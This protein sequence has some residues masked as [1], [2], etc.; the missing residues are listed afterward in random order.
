MRA[1]VL[2]APG[3]PVTV[4]EV[5]LAAPRAGEV[6]VRL[7][8]AGVCHSDLHVRDGD[9]ALPLPLVLGHEGSGTVVETGPGVDALSV[10]DHVVLSWV[11]PCRRCVPCR[12]GHP[13]QCLVASGVVSRGGVLEDGTSRLSA[14][15]R[16]VHH[17]MGVSAFAEE[18]VV[19]AS[20]AIRIDPAAPLEVV[21]LV[22]C[23][24]ATGVGAVR[25]TAKVEAGSTVVVLGCGGVGLSVVQGARLAGAERI[26][27]V[28]LRAEKTALART[29]GATD[30]VDAS[31]SD[32]VEVVRELFPDGVDYAFDAIGGRVLTEQC[33][34]VLGMGGTAVV[35]GIP[36]AGVR[37]SFDAGTLV[38]KEQRILGSNYGGIDP[39]RDI[40]QL[41]DAYLAG[42]LLLD[43]LVSRRRPLEE[44]A[45]S[46]DEL[47]AGTALRQLLIP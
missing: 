9:W 19:P 24:V 1:A 47:A 27:A 12:R 4:E 7:A 26:V 10:G 17:Y 28:D 35:V 43:E 5:D 38:A 39:A 13:A 46:L 25:N 37:P 15:G 31:A 40:P 34:A 20:G 14:G 41:V 2:H 18:A 32:T 33:V 30:V 3:T 29:L 6:R 21:S 23:G 16:T 45:A 36:P 44:A 8:A 42:D 22:G 11:A